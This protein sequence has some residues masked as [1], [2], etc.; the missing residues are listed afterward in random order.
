M[1]IDG[2]RLT[3]KTHESRNFLLYRGVADSAGDDRTFLFKFLKK[4]SLTPVDI[5]RLRLEYEKIQQ[6]DSDCLVK[7]YKAMSIDAEDAGFVIVMED[8]D[9]TPLSAYRNNG[10][11]DL[12]TV[13][14]IGIQAATAIN[15]IHALDLLHGDIRPQNI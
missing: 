15:H 3:E 5:A 7:I 2:F 6:T 4:E 13:L 8:F 9:G 14:S 10:P 1:N 11:I 12:E